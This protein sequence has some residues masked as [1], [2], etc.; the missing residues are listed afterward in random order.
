LGALVTYPDEIPAKV[1]A[2]VEGEGYSV[3][4]AARKLEISEDT[5]RYW[6]K[7]AQ[8]TTEGNK[9]LLDRW[10]R[11]VG[12]S[13]DLMQRGLDV[14]DQDDTNQLAYKSLQTLNIIAGTG[15]DKLL[16]SEESKHP[17]FSGPITIILNAQ[18]DY[19]DGEV[20]NNAD[21]IREDG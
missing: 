11:R 12:R 13:L 3:A 14:I 6:L 10:H 7:K 20:V 4:G 17:T 18:P 19:I 16:K 5:A 8:E 1:L 9:P 2:L 15:T 21:A